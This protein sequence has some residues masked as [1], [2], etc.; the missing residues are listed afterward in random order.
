MD[1][2]WQHDEMRPRLTKASAHTQNRSEKGAGTVYCHWADARPPYQQVVQHPWQQ[3][4]SRAEL[5][6]LEQICHRASGHGEESAAGET[7]EKAEDQV[8]RC[9]QKLLSAI[10]RRDGRRTYGHY[11]RMLLVS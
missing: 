8:D 3:H 7:A 1:L 5:V 11:S 2:Y 10:P 6:I 9:E 4:D